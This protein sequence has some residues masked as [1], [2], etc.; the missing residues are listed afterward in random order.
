MSIDILVDSSTLAL[1]DPGE[2]LQIPLGHAV[3]GPVY[4]DIDLIFQGSGKYRD[5][6]ERALR[7]RFPE[8][9]DLIVNII[10]EGSQYP[11]GANQVNSGIRLALDR[12]IHKSWDANIRVQPREIG[13]LIIVVLDI[14]DELVKPSPGLIDIDRP[15]IDPHRLNWERPI[16]D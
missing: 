6:L 1:I 3:N 5:I 10:Q 16:R 4:H 2:F 12:H 8:R 13:R 15:L 14:I 7:L 11:I 9:L